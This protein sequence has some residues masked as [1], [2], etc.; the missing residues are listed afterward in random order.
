MALAGFLSEINVEEWVIRDIV[1]ILEDNASDLHRGHPATLPTS[2]LGG[3]PAGGT[4][5]HHTSV[6]HQHVVEA[7]EQMAVG[8]RGYMFNVQRFHK[9][10]TFTDEDSGQQNGH[11]AT[12]VN[13]VVPTVQQ[14][15]DCTTAPDVT[16]N[17]SCTIPTGSDS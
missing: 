17:P 11:I 14:S 10:M 4:L 8:L 13:D 9:D 15:N 1:T 3:S 5:G 2:C 7:M 12:K 16:T 6:A